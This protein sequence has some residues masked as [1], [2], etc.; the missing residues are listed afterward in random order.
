MRIINRELLKQL[1]NKS[2]SEYISEISIHT[3]FMRY[4]QEHFND[5]GEYKDGLE[6][7]TRK[8]SEAS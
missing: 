6:S 5:K 7:S 4:G 3:L 8:E 2:N 1:I